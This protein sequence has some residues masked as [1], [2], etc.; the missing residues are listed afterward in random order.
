MTPKQKAWYFR[1]WNLARKRLVALADMTPAEAELSRHEL[2]VRALGIDKSSSALT[3]SDLDK[4]ISA[5]R[6]ISRPSD[7]DSQIRQADQERTR[8][9]WAIRHLGLPDAYLDDIAGKIFQGHYTHWTLLPDDK[10]ILLRYTATAR[11]RSRAKHP[12][13]SVPQAHG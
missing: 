2:H 6:S 7:L 3:N 12:A 8:L 1:E 11:A 10:L 13:E 9:I 4:V 5:F